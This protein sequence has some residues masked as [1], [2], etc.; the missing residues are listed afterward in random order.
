MVRA[1]IVRALNYPLLPTRGPCHIVQSPPVASSYRSDETI[2]RREFWN[3]L[4]Q[5]SSHLHGPYI[6][7]G[8]SHCFYRRERALWAVIGTQNSGG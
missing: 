1:T 4:C 5:A 7:C 2:S 8:T 6:T 3:H